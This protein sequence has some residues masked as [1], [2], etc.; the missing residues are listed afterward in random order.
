MK[1]IANVM[2]VLDEAE[3]IEAAID[4][5]LLGCDQIIVIDQGS[6]DGT[7]DILEYFQHYCSN[8]VTWV[9]S[10]SQTFLTRGEQFFRNLALDLVFCDVAMVTD[11][12][13]ILGDNWWVKVREAF[14]NPTVGAV[15]GNYWQLCGTSDFCTPDSPL[16]PEHGLRPFFFRKCDTLRVGDAMQGTKC[17]TA[18]VGIKP[19]EIAVLPDLDIFHMGYA[20]SD[21]TARFTR[22][23]TRG[24][25]TACRQ[26]EEAL[27]AEFL[28]AAKEEPL[29]MLTECVPVP[30]DV[31]A[32]MPASIR[33]PKF[34]C[35]YNPATRR[36]TARHPL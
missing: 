12:D 6:T 30:A 29:N 14:E 34:R 5:I 35:D 27:K 31:H 18:Y 8:K 15:T 1:T 28:K 16:K 17:H 9:S 10:R 20:K 22:N 3:F 36:I 7:Q 23:I 25:W 21:L 2:L 24:D 33:E 32:R 11:G 4:S 19:K 26:N 13:E